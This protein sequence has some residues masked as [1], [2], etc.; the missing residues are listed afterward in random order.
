MDA[1]NKPGNPT[2]LGKIFSVVGK[3]KRNSKL[4]G[5]QMRC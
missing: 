4:D 1:S 2:E 5:M 3:K